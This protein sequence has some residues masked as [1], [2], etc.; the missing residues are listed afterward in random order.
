MSGII[1]H[2]PNEQPRFV[3]VSMELLSCCVREVAGRLRRLLGSTLGLGEEEHFRLLFKE[4]DLDEEGP[5]TAFMKAMGGG[6]GGGFRPPCAVRVLFRLL[7]GKGGFGALLRSQKGGKKTT[8]FDAMRDLSGRRLRHSKAVERIKEWMEKQKREDELVA[9]VSGEGPELPKPAP[10]AEKLSPEF[11][12]QLKRGAL[13]QKSAVGEGLRTLATESGI[14]ASEPQKRQRMEAAGGSSVG[15]NWQSAF[16]ALG[17]LSSPSNTDDSGN[18]GTKEDGNEGQGVHG[19]SPVG[20]SES[21]CVAARSSTV[22]C[23]VALKPASEDAPACRV[24]AIGAMGSSM[25]AGSSSGGDMPIAATISNKVVTS[26]AMCSSGTP[27]SA[28]GSVV[29]NSSMVISAVAAG[30]ATARSG[31]E[32]R[33]MGSG[34]AS[35]VSAGTMSSH[36]SDLRVSGAEGQCQA[37][38][39]EITLGRESSVASDAG[40]EVSAGVTLVGSAAVRLS[41]R[42]RRGPGSRHACT[43]GTS[44][45]AMASADDDEELIGPDDLVHYQTVEDLIEMAPAE[46]LKRS[47]Q[48]LGMKC[49]GKPEERAK[50]LFML[51]TT[52]LEDLPKTVFA[53]K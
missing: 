18:E 50:R 23:E 28:M 10:E 34:F 46:I 13:E 8:N 38:E 3:P 24:A 35:L 48:R 36:T 7:G 49:G 1:A 37:P 14:N 31:V 33:N 16:E 4:R 41:S 43:P 17:A 21:S 9:L 52:K 6:G 32:F 44:E 42:G 25:A 53:P 2:V 47:L 20:A 30:S 12:R 19:E 26:N 5:A 27:S 40:P 11:V 45:S 39:H 29:L 15:V 22:G 51:R